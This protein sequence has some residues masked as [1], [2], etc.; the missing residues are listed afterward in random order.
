MK[1]LGWFS[2]LYDQVKDT[3]EFKL[4]TIEMEIT[5]KLIAV[6]KRRSM[7]RSDLAGKLGTSKA[8]V[9]KLLND[10]SNITLRRLLRVSEALDC[11]LKIEIVPAERY[12]HIYQIP[13]PVAQNATQAALRTPDFRRFW[14]IEK[15]DQG[16]VVSRADSYGQFTIEDPNNAS[17]A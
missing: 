3:F 7:S 4:K 2:E 11:N 15:D 16:Q 9:S 8:A 6:M 5:E 13:M 10:G 1:A 17:A 12:T 14:Q